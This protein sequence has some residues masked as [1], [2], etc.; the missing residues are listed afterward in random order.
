[1]SKKISAKPGEASKA[2]LS[3]PG[4]AIT[5]T[6]DN[7]PG[8]LWTWRVKFL[9]G[10]DK[11][12]PRYTL[13]NPD[14]AQGLVEW[15]S[16]DGTFDGWIYYQMRQ[17]EEAVERIKTRDARLMSA[18]DFFDTKPG[19]FF[20]A[21]VIG[22][23]LDFPRIITDKGRVKIGA[24]HVCKDTGI[25]Q[26]KPGYTPVE[27]IQ[28]DPKAQLTRPVLESILE[29]LI[30]DPAKADKLAREGV[31]G[32]APRF[33]ITWDAYLKKLDARARKPFDD[34]LAAVGQYAGK[35]AA[36]LPASQSADLGVA[37]AKR[38]TALA[39]AALEQLAEAL[40]NNAD[41]SAGQ[42]SAARDNALKA[43]TTARASLAA[44]DRLVPF[45]SEL[46]RRRQKSHA[47]GRST[48]FSP[49]P[50]SALPLSPAQAPKPLGP[51][52][53]ARA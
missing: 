33:G 35:L 51:N 37:T 45:A 46:A 8:T 21:D 27:F 52:S 22:P 6:L 16:D 36:Q 44:V 2:P 38:D 4:A 49:T 47:T 20:R 7:T 30:T 18:L 12:P 42:L 5:T 43:A 26:P 23:L 31:N 28:L 24:L 29:P 11:T 15:L 39:V 1:M 48:I 50:F 9:E 14:E 13:A 25:A 17:A 32:F 40:G 41:N 10:D 3:P 53:N 34:L 19:G